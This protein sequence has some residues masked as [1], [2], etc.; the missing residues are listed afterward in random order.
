MKPSLAL[1]LLWLSA[2]AFAKANYTC[3]VRLSKIELKLDGTF[4]S[5]IVK[6]AQTQAVVLVG[7][8]ADITHEDERTTLEFKSS[9]R[10][11]LKFTFKTDSLVN[12]LPVLFGLIEGFTGLD[13]VSTSLKCVK[14]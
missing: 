2:T 9:I 6:D 10:D 11:S 4:S 12:E 7:Q 13:H 8:N 14:K 3:N 1:I 5:V